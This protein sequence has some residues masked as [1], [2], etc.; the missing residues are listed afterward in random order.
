MP[1]PK[2]G[3]RLG[4]SPAHN[5][6][7]VRN[8]AA[9]VILNGKIRTTE[10]KAKETRPFIERMITVAKK[11]DLAAKR[12]LIAELNNEEAA[13]KLV[14]EVAPKYEKRPGGYTRIVKTGYRQGDAALMVQLELV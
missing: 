9:A 4:G 14:A 2:K 3:Y 7:M 1:T 5:R 6:L 13:H 11:G 10:A 12:Q 8:L